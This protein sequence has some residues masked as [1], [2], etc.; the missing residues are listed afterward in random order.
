MREAHAKTGRRPVCK[1]L[2]SLYGHPNA[3]LFWERKYKAVLRAAGFKEMIGWECMFLHGTYKV[4]LS[5][6]VNDSKMVGTVDGMAKE[7]S[8]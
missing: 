6:Y 4:V 8:R 3:G 7:R 2:R 5:V 1:L